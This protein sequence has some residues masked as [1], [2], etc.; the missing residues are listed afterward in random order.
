MKKLENKIAIVYGDGAVGSTVAK[1]FAAEQAKVFFVGRT[2]SK[3][4]S[5]ANEIISNGGI[6]EIAEV[7]ALDESA[8]NNHLDEVIRKAG[9]VDIS[10]N[11]IGF[12]QKTFQSIPL[13]ELSLEDFLLPVTI[14]SQSHFITS[15]AA[16]RQMMKQGGGVILMHTPNASR[17]SPPFSGGLIPAWAAMEALCRSLSVECGEKGVRAVCLLTTALPET[18]LIKEMLESRSKARGI[19]AEQFESIMASTTHRKKLTTLAE[20]A[21][22]AVFVAS[23]EASAISGTIFNL[24]AGTIVY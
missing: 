19:T 6:V 18:P 13:T 11:A 24:T 3:L 23:D 16:A 12:R 9:R 1:A 21:N 20:L 8:V 7:D 2:L 14:Y 22:A 5:V 4:K 10:F 15:K 17:L